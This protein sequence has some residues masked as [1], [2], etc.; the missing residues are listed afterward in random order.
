MWMGS[1]SG[2]TIETTI[3]V[4]IQP[5]TNGGQEALGQLSGIYNTATANFS[6]TYT[7]G[8]TV[9]S[10]W[11]LSSADGVTYS[12]ASTIAPVTAANRSGTRTVT[13][14]GSGTR[15]QVWFRL[16]TQVGTAAAVDG[17]PFSV[18]YTPPPAAPKSTEIPLAPDFYVLGSVTGNTQA[19]LLWYRVNDTQNRDNVNYYEL[20]YA[21]DANFSG[22]T[23]LNVGNSAPELSMYERVSYTASGLQDNTTAYFQVRAV[24]AAGTG[25][26]SEM[27]SIDVRIQEGPVFAPNPVYPSNGATGV[28]KTPALEISVTDPE[29]DPLYC[30]FEISESPTGPWY[31]RWGHG[32]DQSFLNVT[33]MQET[34]WNPILKR[35]TKYYWKVVVQ[36]EGRYL[37][38][39]N[40]SWPTSPIYEFT[41]ANLGGSYVL[42]NVTK[43]SGDL[44]VHERITYRLTVT[45]NGNERSEGNNIISY[46]LK[47]GIENRFIAAGFGYVPPID[48]G[49]SATTDVAVY[50]QN[51]IIVGNDGLSYDNVLASGPNL[52]RFKSSPYALATPQAS[53]DYTINY[54]NQ[55]GPVI[56]W[57]VRGKESNRGSQPGGYI[58]LEYSITDDT[59]TSRVTVE[60]R[61]NAASPFQ[62]L[63]DFVGGSNYYA[64][65]N[66]MS[67]TG[68]LAVTSNCC[69]RWNIRNHSGLKTRRVDI[70]LLNILK[71]RYHLLSFRGITRP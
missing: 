44:K 11:L 62:I 27:R 39:Y 57:N 29:G 15:S 28:S 32:G 8:A 67:H 24:N 45:N 31:C 5:T 48:P 65:F 40:G 16:R 14:A 3:N 7:L 37:D 34:D 1:T 56:S 49:Q 42:S 23:V 2:K 55:G 68:T 52:V 70:L 51:A 38:Y 64:D 58:N 63:D 17:T 60:M 19:N 61:P 36:E 10:G 33:K 6:L 20:R 71:Y 66:T 12:V 18:A 26:W 21:T 47:N 41:T 22:A 53:L 69:L 4:T 9:T 25:P 54:A 35:N 59:R 30:N 43:I 13:V 46:L 50:F